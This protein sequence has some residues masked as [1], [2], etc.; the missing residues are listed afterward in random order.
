MTSLNHSELLEM[1][2][3]A[4]QASYSPY[5]KYR[6]G[7]AVVTGDGVVVTGANIENA[8]YGASV[9]AETNAITSAIAAGATSIDTVAV[10][11]LDGDAC[12]PCGNCRQVM[13]E[14]GVQ[15]VVMRGGNGMP[16]TM[17]L[18][19]LLPESFGP[20]FLK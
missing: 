14:F 11:C 19:D 20:E 4:A 12:T 10:V 15:T 6:V 16:V 18:A 1:A 3:A 5:S 13:R 8:A 9:C 2:V 7:A 17:A